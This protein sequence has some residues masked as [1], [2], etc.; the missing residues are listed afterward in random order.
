M[1]LVSELMKGY[2]AAELNSEGQSKSDNSTW[3][4]C[5]AIADLK[6]TYVVSCQEYGKHKRAGHPLAKDI[7]RLM[8]T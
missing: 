4:Q 8:T 3:Q 5:Q 7:L 1:L 2:K 6:F